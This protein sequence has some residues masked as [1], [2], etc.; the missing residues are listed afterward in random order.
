MPYP[1]KPI[2]NGGYASLNPP[3]QGRID[4]IKADEYHYNKRSK[5]IPIQDRPEDTLLK[6]EHYFHQL[7]R[8]RA[9][10]FIR[11]QQLELPQLPQLT[12]TLL[13]NKSPD[14][15]PIPGMYGGFS[16]ELKTLENEMVLITE[17]WC[18]VVGGSEQ[19]HQ[20]TTQG[21]ELL[22]EGFV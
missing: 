8:E 11:R 3:Y 22:E 9:G 15:F 12:A 20:I 6:I 2:E 13:A 5:M 21:I 10:Y 16:Y 7:I 19:K 18:R 1:S 17:S 4:G 14:W